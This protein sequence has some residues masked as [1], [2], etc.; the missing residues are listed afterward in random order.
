MRAL[1]YAR[2]ALKSDQNIET[3]LNTCFDKAKSLGVSEII[4]F[5]DDGFS[6]LD[7]SR[8]ALIDLLT[9][10]QDGDII[11]VS[12]ADKLSRDPLDLI[13]IPE[14]YKVHIADNHEENLL[15]ELSQSLKNDLKEAI[16]RRKKR[17]LNA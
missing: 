15:F 8:P 6:G 5:V 3:Q 1:I 14:H 12:H 16:K 10:Y 13:E 9:T 2:S 17:S 11:V 7:R 4:N